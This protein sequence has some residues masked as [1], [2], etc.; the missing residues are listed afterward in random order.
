V[1]LASHIGQRC[2]GPGVLFT[3]A[4]EKQDRTRELQ[5]VT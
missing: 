2:G 4:W 3:A 5:T 1:E